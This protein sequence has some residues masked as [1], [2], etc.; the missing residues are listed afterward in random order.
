MCEGGPQAVARL[1]DRGH[2]RVIS[3][4]VTAA[5]GYPSFQLL[6]SSAGVRVYLWSFQ[7]LEGEGV[8]SWCQAGRWF[9]GGQKRQPPLPLSSCSRLLPRASLMLRR[10]QNRSQTW[11]LCVVYELTLRVK[12]STAACVLPFIRASLSENVRHE[13]SHIE[14]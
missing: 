2:G 8:Q 11:S 1:P 5:M 13:H 10:S 12:E 14:I 4:T 3:E 7:S 9:A 6:S